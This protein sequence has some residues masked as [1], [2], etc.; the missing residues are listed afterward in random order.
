[1]ETIAESVSG[2]RDSCLV[3]ACERPHNTLVP[4]RW[5]AAAVAIV[6]GDRHRMRRVAQSSGAGDLRWISAYLSVKDPHSMALWWHQDWWCWSHPISLRAQAPQMALLCYLDS[7]TVTRGAL[8]VLPGSHLRSTSLHPLLPREGHDPAAIGCDHP[9]MRDHPDQVTVKARAGD[10]VLVDYRV[11]HGAHANEAERP[12]S[13]LIVNFAPGWSGLPSEIRGHLIRG[14]ALPTD[15]E[16]ATLPLELMRWLPT[17][18]GIRRDLPLSRDA[19]DR[20]A[21][22]PERAQTR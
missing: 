6:L 9:A 11:L 3:T 18:T 19:P 14:F 8:R 12:R 20:F 10:A 1:M 15:A 16:R 2:L 22:A 17:H 7:T 21:A 4:L 13:C 5:N